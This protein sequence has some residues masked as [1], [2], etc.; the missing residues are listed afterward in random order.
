MS[1]IFHFWCDWYLYQSYTLCRF[2]FIPCT[3]VFPDQQY[4]DIMCRLGY[5]DAKYMFFNEL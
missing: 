5:I 3:P 1:P 2:F 4:C